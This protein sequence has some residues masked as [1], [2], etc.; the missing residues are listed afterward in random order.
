MNC[1]LKE[2]MKM[3][4]DKGREAITGIFKIEIPCFRRISNCISMK[5]LIV[6]ILLVVSTLPSAAQ[7]E[8]DA[9][10]KEIEQNN[11]TLS[12]LREQM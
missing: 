7:S 8:V 6:S 9:V 2:N 12:S 5:I 10:L 4:R 11:S 1:C 3:K